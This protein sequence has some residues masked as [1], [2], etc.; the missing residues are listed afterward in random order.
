[1]KHPQHMQVEPAPNFCVQP[2]EKWWIIFIRIICKVSEGSQEGRCGPVHS[3][4]GWA[5][6]IRKTKKK[7]RFQEN[8]EGLAGDSPEICVFLIF[9]QWFLLSRTGEEWAG[10]CGLAWTGPGW[11]RLAWADLDLPGL[12]RAVWLQGSNDVSHELNHFEFI[13][14]PME[15]L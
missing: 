5:K 11:P 6:T 13:W 8:L 2:N 1:M 9:F 7:Q 15:F 3:R 12:D 10:F 4:R 14:I